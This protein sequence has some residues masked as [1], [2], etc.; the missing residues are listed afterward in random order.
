MISDE[1]PEINVV[2]PQTLGNTSASFYL[3][4]GNVDVVL[5]RALAAGATSLR[6]V[7]DQGYGD[8]NGVVRDPIGHRWMVAT[9]LPEGSPVGE[10]QAV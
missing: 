5:E 4:V 7:A 8:R 3:Y 10:A 1:Y 9:R 2:G 6:P